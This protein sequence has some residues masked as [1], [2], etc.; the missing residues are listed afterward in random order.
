[1]TRA[2]KG[3]EREK[4]T[5]LGSSSHTIGTI[6]IEGGREGG[7]ALRTG[8]HLLGRLPPLGDGEGLDD[9]NT[10][11]EEDEEEGVQGLKLL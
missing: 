1:M 9:G 6:E 4:Y 10:E 11:D 5:S 7:R 3:T 8:A 2:K